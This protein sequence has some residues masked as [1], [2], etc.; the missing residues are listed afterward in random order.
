MAFYL[1]FIIA[2]MIF[3]SLHLES[4]FPVLREGLCRKNMQNPRAI[5]YMEDIPWRFLKVVC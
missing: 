4:F 3:L 5:G 2:I 1:I